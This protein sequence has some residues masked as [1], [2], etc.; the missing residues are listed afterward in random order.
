MSMRTIAMIGA[1][2]VLMAFRPTISNG[3]WKATATAIGCAAKVSTLTNGSAMKQ[4]REASILCAA[5][6]LVATMAVAADNPEFSANYVLPGCRDALAR[7][8]KDTGAG[9]TGLNGMC[10]GAIWSAAVI[11]QANMLMSRNRQ[12]H[13]DW[14]C[15]DVPESA[16]G[17][18]LIRIVVHY[19]DTHPELTHQNFTLFA[20][21]ALADAWPCRF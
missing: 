8:E 16:S 17:E 5:M 13:P 6:A 7:H 18:Q 21:D 10:I 4:V 14:L 19:A 15:I 11:G 2:S 3:G 20:F 1:V 9:F 12:G